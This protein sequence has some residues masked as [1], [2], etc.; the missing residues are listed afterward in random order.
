MTG[1]ADPL[2]AL[3]NP[4]IA[5]SGGPSLSYVSS[6]MSSMQGEAR[7]RRASF[8]YTRR[9]RGSFRSGPSASTTLRGACPECN[10]RT[11]DLRLRLIRLDAMK[12]DC[13]EVGA[14]HT[15]PLRIPKYKFGVTYL[16]ELVGT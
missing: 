4:L 7:S 12:P 1:V 14:R 3:K 6:A 16:M 2:R 15:V 13:R 9:L 5:Q 11:Q 10:R 8:D